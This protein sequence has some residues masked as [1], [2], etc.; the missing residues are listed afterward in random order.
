MNQRPECEIRNSETV[1]RKKWRK[2][3][4]IR[5]RLTLPEYDSSCLEK[6]AKDL[7]MRLHEIKKLP[8]SKKKLLIE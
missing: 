5:H 4:K 3:M 1:K 8:Y 7:H 2:H 6:N